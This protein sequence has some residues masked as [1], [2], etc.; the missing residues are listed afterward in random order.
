[1]KFN[2]HTVEVC[3]SGASSKFQKSINRTE[4][5]LTSAVCNG[6]KCDEVTFPRWN[7]Q[8]V[9]RN[10]QNKCGDKSIVGGRRHPL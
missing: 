1:M 8:V 3:T 7:W 5:C 4:T 6:N 10:E 2:E 9:W